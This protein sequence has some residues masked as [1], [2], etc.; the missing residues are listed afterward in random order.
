MNG[1]DRA[2]KSGS[3]GV[4]SNPVRLDYCTLLARWQDCGCSWCGH[5]VSKLSDGLRHVR[6]AT[7]A[8]DDTPR[9]VA[10]SGCLRR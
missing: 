1:P 5:Y 10:D 2:R 6:T 8:A 9:T 4:G 3:K 7:C